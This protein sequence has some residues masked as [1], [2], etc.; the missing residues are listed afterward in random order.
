M[1]SKNLAGLAVYEVHGATG[2]AIYPF[3]LTF[4]DFAFTIQPVMNRGFRGR[5]CE[6]E[7]TH[8]IHPT[9]RTF[10]SPLSHDFRQHFDRAAG[11]F[12]GADTAALAIVEVDLEAVAAGEAA[13]RFI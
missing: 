6:N 12:L 10:A 11:T 8:L 7:C 5:T 4:V 1:P 2:S 13:P 9:T 3:V